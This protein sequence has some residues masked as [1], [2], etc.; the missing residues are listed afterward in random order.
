[1]PAPDGPGG[2]LAERVPGSHE[3]FVAFL[4]SPD[5]KANRLKHRP[6]GWAAGA[7][8]LALAWTDRARA[9]ASDLSLPPPP[10]PGWSTTYPPEDTGPQERRHEHEDRTDHLTAGVIGGVG[11]PR[12]IQIEGLVK[13]ERLLAFGLEYSV[14]PTLTIS[15]AD[16]SA[17]AL[18]GDVRCFPFRNGFFV[19]LRVGRQ[20]AEGETTTHVPGYG[21]LTESMAVDTWFLNPRFGFLWTWK[22]GFTL[23]IDAGIEFPV[24]AQ[25][26][27]SLPPGVTVTKELESIRNTVGKS[28]L[29]TF[30]LLR[31]GVLL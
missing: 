16:A 24:A 26:S 23:G 11:F 6:A 22:A 29:P 12:P 4:T 21:S 1:M 20:H 8:L 3:G 31:F 10:P 2:A 7:C 17:W 5:A 28:V 15:G 9:E 27:Q 18:A 14:L 30:D 25:E 13:V 19:G